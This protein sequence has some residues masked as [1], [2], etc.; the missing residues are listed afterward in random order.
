[1]HVRYPHCH[2]PIELLDDAELS[3]ISCPSCGS[4]FSLL[5]ETVT[6]QRGKAKTIGHFNLMEEVGIGAFGSVW[7]ANDT[8]LDRTVAVKIPRKGQLEADETEQ[9]LR[10]ARAAAQLRH[11][12][13]VSVY[14]VGRDDNQVY[15]VSDY[16]DG[17]TLSDWSEQRQLSAR[18]SA[19]LCAKVADALHHA[20]EQGVIHRDLKP[21]NIMM[22]LAGEPH[23]MDFGLAK[24][25]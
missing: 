21:S 22:D 12:N 5:E 9:F 11:S 3:D 13:V 10:D 4:S 25:R 6:H 18:E 19:E 24:S 7:K 23:I 15:I 17:A 20:H 14:E 2:N 8:K 1:M 16:V